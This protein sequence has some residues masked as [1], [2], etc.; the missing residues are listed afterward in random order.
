MTHT[1][2]RLTVRGVESAKTGAMLADG[3]GLYYSRVRGGSRWLF[4][5][6]CNGRRREMG[7]GS[8]PK[9]NLAQARKLAAEARDTVA[10]G[11]DPIAAR[12]VGRAQSTTA[13][14][15]GQFADDYITSV[16]SGWKSDV[17]RHQWRQCL[18]DHAATLHNM[19]VAD[20]T[21][22]DVLAVLRPIWAD[23]AE[24]ANRVRARIEKI[25]AAAKVLELRPMDSQNPAAWHGHLELL[26]PKRPKLQ[27]GHHAALPFADA[28]GFMV[29]LR[30]RS[31]L[32]ARC[33]EFTILTAARS[34]EAL[35][36]TWAEID[37]ERKLWTVS[38]ERMKAGS[39]HV[40]P[41]S[42]AALAL[43]ESMKP[44]LRRPTDLVFAVGG[45]ARS[46]MAM[47]MLLR[48]MGHGGITT[49][50]FR[51]TFRDWA[52]DATEFPRD[53]VEQ[54]L[55]HAV[56]DATERAYRRGTA[57]ERRRRLMDAW[58]GYLAPTAAAAVADDFDALLDVAA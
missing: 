13:T 14:T 20:I 3:G 23:K 2:N 19:P 37:M 24:T 35:G 15:F 10:A 26:L 1:L 36:A 52:G 7:L 51:S 42:P 56:G 47:S 40:V 6:R 5:W 30:A 12:R 46:N 4:V 55:A 11:N 54:A 33:L 44:T 21:T 39:A 25:L 48:R 49:H 32:A 53:L 29:A 50:G 31:A 18:R 43:L 58:A 28:P 16:E 27:R 9:V 8:Y 38:A 45:V 17:H 41:L 22:N 57:I 34:G